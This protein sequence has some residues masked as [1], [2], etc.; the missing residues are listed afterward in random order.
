MVGQNDG[1]II[2]SYSR[3]TVNGVD[4]IGGLVGYQNGGSISYSYATGSVTNTGS[5]GTKGGIIGTLNAGTVSNSYWDTQT[6]GVNVS[7]GSDNSFGKTT[8]QMTTQ[9]TFTA[10]N[11]VSEWFIHPAY[12]SGYPQLAWTGA[13]PAL[14]T[15]TNVIIHKGTIPGTMSIAWDDMQASW[16]GI[17]SGT[18]PSDMTYLGWTT[19]CSIT[20]TEGTNEFIKVTSGNGTA[21]G[22]QLLSR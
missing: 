19:N 4:N 16:Y 7:S 5:A 17:Y 6:T 13:P 9:S 14:N 11:F 3:A 21:P 2:N 12:N 20:I 18:T 1:I 15:P 8:A 22:I 10:W